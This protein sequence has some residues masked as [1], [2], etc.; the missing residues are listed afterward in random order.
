MFQGKNGTADNGWYKINSGI[1][2]IS[3]VGYLY[4]DILQ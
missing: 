2:D 1:Y 3:K 4:N